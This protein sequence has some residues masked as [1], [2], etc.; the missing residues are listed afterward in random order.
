MIRI[1]LCTGA[2]YG[3]VAVMLGAF[4]AHGL[5]ARLGED[6]LRAWQTGVE[7]QFY[8]ALALLLT[9]LLLNTV[10]LSTALGH[11]A[12]GCFVVG[13][14]LFSGSLYGLALGGPRLLG[15]IT[16]IGGLLLMAGWLCLVAAVLR[17]GPN[18]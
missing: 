12:A 4:G 18:A 2:M 5:R 1:W 8:H 10:Q 17:S 6:M 7:Y 16:P 11:W 9:G 13:V 14:L 3:L 15:P